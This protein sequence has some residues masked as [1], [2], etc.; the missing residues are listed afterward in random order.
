MNPQDRK[1][2][3]KLVERH[4]QDQG[5]F[6]VKTKRKKSYGSDNSP[7]IYDFDLHNSFHKTFINYKILNALI[8]KDEIIGLTLY[9]QKKI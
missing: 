5:I 2:T 3:F 7:L 1:N 4:L 8:E 6:I 9:K